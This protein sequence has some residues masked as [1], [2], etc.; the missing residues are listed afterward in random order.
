MIKFTRILIALILL[1]M[2]KFIDIGIYRRRVIVPKE[3]PRKK[4]EI[5]NRFNEM[6]KDIVKGLP[7][8]EQNILLQEYIIGAIGCIGKNTNEALYD[9]IV[10]C[11]VFLSEIQAEHVMLLKE[12]KNE[13][14]N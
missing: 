6:H 4:E 5:I 13:S 8:S 7:R 14:K 12:E 3:L 9:M 10:I 2:I 11:N 1:K